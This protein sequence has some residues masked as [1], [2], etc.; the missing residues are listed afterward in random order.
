MKRLINQYRPSIKVAGSRNKSGKSNSSSQSS[1]V[2]GS[3]P[4][5][6]N[7]LFKSIAQLLGQL[8]KII[9]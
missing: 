9:T 2:D 1:G 6:K 3:G 8:Q 5:N 7:E 4:L